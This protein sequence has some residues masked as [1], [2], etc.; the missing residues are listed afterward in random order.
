MCF[1]PFGDLLV[2]LSISSVDSPIGRGRC[3]DSTLRWL[4]YNPRSQTFMHC[5][6]LD[7]LLNQ[8]WFDD[9]FLGLQAIAG[10]LLVLNIAQH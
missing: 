10:Q 4:A 1:D 9:F 3:S 7:T 8:Q 5:R 6:K 2:L